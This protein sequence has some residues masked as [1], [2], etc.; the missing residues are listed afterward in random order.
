MNLGKAISLVLTASGAMVF[1]AGGC[2]SKAKVHS[3]TSVPEPQQTSTTAL[4]SSTPPPSTPWERSSQWAP[5]GRYVGGP[6]SDPAKLAEAAKDFLA[7]YTAQF[8]EA[9]KAQTLAYWTAANSG[10]K[11]DFDAFAQADLRLKTLHSNPQAYKML[12]E[13]LEVTEGAHPTTH[14][15]VVDPVTRRALEVALLAYKGN[16]LPK[17]ILEQMVT[18]SSDIE[19]TFNTFRATYD[20]KTYT[21]NELLEMLAKERNSK[22]R[23]GMWE[24]L[25]QVGDAVASKIANLAKVRNEAAKRLGYANYWD[26]QLR[27]QEHDPAQILKLFE[28]LEAVT[29]GPYREMKQQLD[30]ELAPKFGIKPESMMPWHYDNP[31]FQEAPP[32][33]KVNLDDFYKGKQKEDIVAIAK[34]FFDDIGLDIQ[35]VLERSDLYDRSGKDQHAFCIAIDRQGD[36]RT[37]LNIKPTEKWMDTMLH[38]QGHGVYY[39]GIDYTLPYNLR[40]AAHILTTE[41]IAMLFGAL[42]KNPAWMIHYAGANEKAVKKAEKDILEQRRREQLIF[43]RWAMVMLYFEKALYENP[44]QNL[45]KTWWDI[46]EKYQMLRRPEGRTASDWASKPHFTIAPVYYHNYMLGELFAA[47]LRAKLA[48]LANHNGPTATLSFN[49]QK[50]FGS[51]LKESVFK[52]S[53]RQRW[54]RFVEQS[55]GQPLS[56]APFGKEVT[57]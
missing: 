16:Q 26:M 38:E 1:G 9:E 24:A 36:V 15:P 46:V 13:L 21:N 2:Q 50:Q 43:A 52:P 19:N 28:E 27:L 32:S 51:Y 57:K 53:M 34:R 55:T 4:A 48:S 40:E 35:P 17:D 7:Y 12:T 11:E 10:K 18:Q 6:S 39:L 31:F 25:K 49:G 29:N 42:A 5:T 56:V 33:A 22:K 20:G 54:S 37:L 45:A 8:S 23:Q 41:G 44:D 3:E 30:R 14:Q 47:Q